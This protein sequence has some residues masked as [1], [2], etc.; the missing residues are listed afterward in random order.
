M[1]ALN[2]LIP[3][4]P[5]WV[6]DW[7]GLEPQLQSFISALAKTQQNPL[8]HGEGDVWTHTKLVC[9]ALTNMADF[10]SLDADLRTA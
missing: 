3:A 8:H 5:S 6:I 10:R 2:R 4:P 9:Q 7:L 1:N